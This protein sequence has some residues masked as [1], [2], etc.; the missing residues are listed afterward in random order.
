MYLIILT[1][2]TET[3]NL[4]LTFDHA[5]ITIQSSSFCITYMTRSTRHHTLPFGKPET[6]F[7]YMGIMG[8][9]IY[10]TNVFLKLDLWKMKIQ[11]QSRAFPKREG[12]ARISLLL[13]YSS[14]YSPLF[15][16]TTQISLPTIV[17]HTVRSHTKGRCDRSFSLLPEVIHSLWKGSE[18]RAQ[19]DLCIG[20]IK[21]KLKFMVM[22]YDADRRQ[23]IRM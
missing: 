11:E 14:N 4:Y 20:S 21:I 12:L 10:A 6:G 13:Q 1:T 23:P 19:H 3:T 2:L 16:F 17:A 9:D 8:Q 5:E 18:A 15:S 22:S 7:L